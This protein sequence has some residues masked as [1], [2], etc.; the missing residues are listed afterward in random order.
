MPP[1]NERNALYPGSFDPPTNGH[2]WVMGKVAGDYDKG[3]IAV[4][5]NP[6]RPPD[7]FTITE[8]VEMLREIIAESPNLG[9]LEATSFAGL[10]QADFAEMLGVK[11]IVRGTRDSGDFDAENRAKAINRT[12]NPYIDTVFLAPPHELNS[13]SSTAV[14]ELIGF[15]GWESIVARM[16]PRPVFDRLNLKQQERDRASL[17]KRF[18]ELWQRL[19]A[20][21]DPLPV[22]DY[23]FQMHAEAHRAYHNNNH[24]KMCHNELDLVRSQAED[25][26]SLQLAIDT[27]DLFYETQPKTPGEV[28]DNEGKSAEYA[29]K[30]VTED[31]GL[32]RDFADRVAGLI[33]ATNH[34]SSPMTPDEQ[35]MVD[36]DLAIFGRSTRLFDLYE[37]QIRKEYIWVPEDFFAKRRAEILEG[38]LPHIDVEPQ[39]PSVYLTVPFKERYE[40]QAITNLQRSIDNLQRKSP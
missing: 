16:V 13:I 38:F 12:I 27:H 20:Q 34:T 26:D 17:E 14:M 5:L 15:E 31:M 6:R 25:P 7:R 19:G 9:N 23:I 3:F 35:L 40:R 37:E 24:R 8:S 2:R 39:R 36:I 30:T 11:T 4:G 21:G 28:I 33:L 22:A 29:V 10:C 32:S 1:V 18:V